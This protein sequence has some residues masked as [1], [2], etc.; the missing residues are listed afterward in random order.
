MS[1][2][3]TKEIIRTIT[4]P[5]DESYK[6]I[7]VKNNPVGKEIFIMT[8]IT[9]AEYKKLKN[10]EDIIVVRGN[11]KFNITQDDIFCYGDIDFNNGS[12]DCE[13]ID[14]FN[15]LDNLVAKGV[16]IPSRYDYNKHECTTNKNVVLWTETFKNSVLCRYLHGCL[17]KPKYTLIFREVK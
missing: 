4:M 12:D 11:A 10:A 14:T 15:W 1:N 8:G 5:I 6:I 2:S 16:C 17:G 9:E 7:N 3:S 13:Q